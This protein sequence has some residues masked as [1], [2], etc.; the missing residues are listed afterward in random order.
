VYDAWVRKSFDQLA[1][2]M[3]ARYAKFEKG[4]TFA[5]LSP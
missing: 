3:P 4:E 5:T 1:L 2:L